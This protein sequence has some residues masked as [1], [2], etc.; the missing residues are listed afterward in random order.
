LRKHSLYRA[1]RTDKLTLAALEATLEIHRRGASFDEIPVL[2]MIGM[3]AAE[4]RE[5]AEALVS[6]LQTLLPP[7]PALRC[8]IIEGQSAIGGGSA[9][10]SHPPT[11]LIALSHATLSVDRLEEILRLSTPPVIARIAEGKVL[12]DLRTVAED[13]EAPL[14]AALNSLPG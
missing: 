5:R 9:P 10:L 2:R 1:L 3:S 8:E 14:L 13:E 6:K 4:V 11:A 12:L 7:T